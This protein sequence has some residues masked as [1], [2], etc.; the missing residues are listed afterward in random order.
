M[1][2][3]LFSRRS[4]RSFLSDPIEDAEVDTILRAAF[5]APS[6]MNQRPLHFIVIRG[7]ALDAILRASQN[8]PKGAPVAI[9]VCVDEALERAPRLGDPDAA[10][11]TENMLLAA[12]GL[13]LGSVWSAV[14]AS[15]ADRFRELLGLPDGVRPYS[16]VP[17][18]KPAARPEP[19]DRWDESRVHRDRW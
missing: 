17:I 8:T 2:E 13:G 5:H 10:A 11:A 18:G 3:E 12:E 6:A 15:S 1:M 7:A 9:V 19:V 16:I 14:L 4:V